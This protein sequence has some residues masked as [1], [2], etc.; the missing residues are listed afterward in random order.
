MDPSTHWVVGQAEDTVGDVINR[1]KS[2]SWTGADLLITVNDT[3]LSWTERV[4]E[5]SSIDMYNNDVGKESA[6]NS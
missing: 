1:L 6:L 3:P 2:G 4:H 5:R